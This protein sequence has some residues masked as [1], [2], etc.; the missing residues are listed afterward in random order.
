L[1]WDRTTTKTPPLHYHSERRKVVEME[2]RVKAEKAISLYSILQSPS[3][4]C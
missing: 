3:T 1:F 2:E 4:S